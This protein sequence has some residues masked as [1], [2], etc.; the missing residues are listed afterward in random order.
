MTERYPHVNKAKKYARDITAGKIPACTLVRRACQRFLDDLKRKDN[1]YRFNPEKGE[2]A[3]R[4][5]ESMVHIKGEWAGSRIILQPWQCFI[6][7]NIFSWLRVSDGTRRFSEAYIEIPR[8]NGKS[9]LA[10]GIALAMFL[11][12]GEIGAEI[13]CGATTEDQANEVFYPA[14]Q[15]VELSPYC[16]ETFGVEVFAKSMFCNMNMAR[17]KPL[18]GNPGDGGSPHCAIADEYHEHDTDDLVETMKRGMGARRQPLMLEITTAGFNL[19]GPCARQHDY[20]SEI[21]RGQIQ[22]DEL[23]TII[24]TIDDNDE[25]TDFNN[26]IKAN[27]NYG[28]SVY[29]RYLRSAW[30]EA[31]TRA[32][33]QNGCRTK[34][35]NQWM[36]ADLAWLDIEAV[37]KCADEN[38]SPS[39]LIGKNC[40]IS[41]DMASKVDLTVVNLVFWDDDTGEYWFFPRFY[42]P[43][44]TVY[45]PQNK[46]YQA[47]EMA[48]LLTVTDGNVIDFA[49]VKQSIS[50]LYRQYGAQGVVYD[51]WKATQISQ[52]L[53][54]EGLNMIEVRQTVAN[55]SE[56]MKE[57]EGAVYSR[58]MH[59]DGNKMFLWNFGNVVSHYDH[60]DNVFPNKKYPENKIDGVVTAIM[61]INYAIRSRNAAAPGIVGS[62]G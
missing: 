50:D 40:V 3:C 13:Y 54:R 6:F 17:F 18:I 55:M 10:A 58:R 25:W 1:L 24:Y 2:K 35:L 39:Q 26:W 44:G 51:P 4:F 12:D 47:Y 49:R 29:E 23:F 33:K 45:K 7:V 19:V 56:P 9:V 57:L 43:H 46:R 15:M 37:R 36:N 52:E 16:K 61:A 42:L 27:P 31:T 22:N 38:L 41:L 20:A 53:E 5:L 62:H 59:F 30:K 28:I 14:K 8:K 21:L 32:D 48:G 34:H 11:I 60:K